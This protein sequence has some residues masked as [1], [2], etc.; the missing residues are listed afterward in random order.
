MNKRLIK[1]NDEGGGGGVSTHWIAA[2][3]PASG[4]CL[5]YST[6]G[7]NF[8][9]VNT[10]G[11]PS[12]SIAAS[13]AYNGTYWFAGQGSSASYSTDGI[14]FT[15]V[16]GTLPSTTLY[17]VRWN[18]NKWLGLSTNQLWASNDVNGNNWYYVGFPSVVDYL[19]VANNNIWG[20]KAVPPDNY[21]TYRSTDEGANFSNL[22]A[23]MPDFVNQASALIYYKE[24]HLI[25]TGG[26][27]NVSYYSLDNGN[28][29]NACSGLP[30]GI[31]WRGVSDGTN[32]YLP[33][34]NTRRIYSS[35]DG[36]NFSVTAASGFPVTWG[37]GYIFDGESVWFSDRTTKLYKSNDGFNTYAII[38][39]NINNPAIESN[40]MPAFFPPIG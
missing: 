12:D 29:W 8:S 39:T 18:G 32:V 38:E 15:A 7:V 14:N 27:G 26:Y 28:T 16:T 4:K 30:G 23:T 19:T 3:T 40:S 22:T 33:Y 10:T 35:N 31:W 25:L 37:Q 21:N 1:S 17:S 24:N 11:L 13:I 36:I 9:D 2:G 5:K 34:E 6:D 20:L